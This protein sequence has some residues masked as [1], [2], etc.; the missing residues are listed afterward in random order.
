MVMVDDADVRRRLDGLAADMAGRGV[1]RSAEWRQAFGEVRRHVFVPRYWHDEEPGAYPARWRMVD[2]ATRDHDQWMRAVYSDRTLATE[3]TGVA[4]DDGHRMHPQV[5]SSSTMPSLVVAMLEELDV[6]DDMRVLEIGT[7]TGYNAALLCERLGDIHVTSIDLNAELVVLAAARL[8]EHGYRPYLVT[9]D[10]A[11]GVPERAPYDRLVAT[12]GLDHIP[13]EWIR[14]TVDGGKILTNLRGPFNAHALISLT[15]LDGTASGRFLAQ[16]GGFMPRR[17]DPLRPYDY[18]LSTD[19]RSSDLQPV[20]GHT[21]LNPQDLFTRPTWGLLAQTLLHDVH[22]RPVY[23]DENTEDS[24]NPKNIG[25]ELASPDGS[26]ARISHAL[27]HNGY[28]TEQLGPRRM[29]DELEVLHHTWTA[30][31]RPGHER[32]GLTITANVDDDPGAA[33]TLW[34]DKP[35]NEIIEVNQLLAPIRAPGPSGGD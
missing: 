21:T 7:G 27:D 23:L 35:D 19:Y 24:E 30:L 33:P 11:E 12:C 13:P 34:L 1:L 4:V 25:T 2:N 14:Q 10:G 8:M 26:W 29:W 9:G 18:S 28:Q 22:Y 16:D 17:T 3:L 15:V 20:T 32:I 31:G 6:T 5:T